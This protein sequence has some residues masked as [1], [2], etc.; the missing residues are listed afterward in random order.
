[1]F[2]NVLILSLEGGRERCICGAGGTQSELILRHQADVTRGVCPC[3]PRIPTSQRCS[4]WHPLHPLSPSPLLVPEC[5]SS[6][7]G[8][9][10]PC[11]EQEGPASAADPAGTVALSGI[12]ASTFHCSAVRLVLQPEPA[13]DVVL[14]S[15]PQAQAVRLRRHSEHRTPS[16]PCPALAR[17][18]WFSV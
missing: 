9:L 1:M 8:Q 14:L 12:P 15:V 3:A 6:W 2:W 5:F 7:C 10:D 13:P 17:L 18:A 16:L 4:V 11:W